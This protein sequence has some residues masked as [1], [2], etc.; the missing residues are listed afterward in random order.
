MILDDY[1]LTLTSL[2][3]ITSCMMVRVQA[4]DRSW[5]GVHCT[6][7]QCTLL[8]CTAL[9]CTAVHCTALQGSNTRPAWGTPRQPC[10]LLP[11]WSALLQP[12]SKLRGSWGEKGAGWDSMVVHKNMDFRNS[13]GLIFIC[14]RNIMR[15]KK[16]SFKTIFDHSFTL[17]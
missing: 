8:Q 6:V 14:V 2:L 1:F 9:Y 11:A 3:A 13:L 4:W 10:D 15:S 17:A 12:W 5:R 7:L 16:N